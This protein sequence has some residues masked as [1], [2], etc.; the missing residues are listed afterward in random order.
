[1]HCQQTRREWA[2]RSAAAAAAYFGLPVLSRASVP[3]A[4]VS[5]VRSR[6]YDS[7]ELLPAL[8]KMFDQ[9]GGLH[10]LVNNKTVSIKI[11]LTGNP[12][13]RLGD[14]LIGD[15][16]Y[17][18]PFV[19]GAT[20]HLLG[21]AGAKRI[22][23]L[24]SPTGSGLPIPEFISR[25]NWDLHAI[26][27]A[28]KN[29]E[30]INTNFPGANNKFARFRISTGGYIFPG[31]DLN[32][33]YSECDVFM[34]LAKMK[35]HATAGIT[36]SMKNCFGMTPCTIY[37]AGA[38]VDEPS[39]TVSGGRQNVCHTG[40]RAPSKSAP[41]ENDPTTPRDGGYRMPRIVTDVCSARPIDIA[42][43]EAVRTMAGSELA[44]PGNDFLSPGLIVAGTNPVTTDAVCV[45]LM[46]YD[47]M[48]E[49]GTA[50]FERCDNTL[51]LAEAIGLGTRD[52][53]R[54]EVRGVQIADARLNFPE[55]R[56]ARPPVLPGQGR[57]QG[58][59]QGQNPWVDAISGATPKAPDSVVAKKP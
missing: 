53:R 13:M 14:N 33:A 18:N 26:L 46:G 24:E 54:I 20:V 28:A 29:V 16:T 55:L 32:P 42:V 31:F 27:N 49:R 10:R 9:L 23:L 41:R 48:S 50:P 40:T 6:T 1:M 56:K 7:A 34:S 51:A 8:K 19:I 5:V 45:A 39:L 25:A 11:N 44:R 15:T 52:L 3:T 12:G 4:P 58:R 21:R 38:G 37:G 30:L 59:G 57:G 2:L 43:V 47:P 36:L 35:E 17:T 22:R